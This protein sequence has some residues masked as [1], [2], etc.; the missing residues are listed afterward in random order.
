MHVPDPPN[1][2]LAN[3]IAANGGPEAFAA[4]TDSER[5]LKAVLDERADRTFPKPPYTMV[6]PP[7]PGAAATVDCGEPRAQTQRL[8]TMSCIG[9]T[10]ILTDLPLVLSGCLPGGAQ[11]RLEALD[12]S[13]VHVADG[14]DGAPVR[15]FCDA[16]VR[17]TVLAASTLF[18][19]SPD[20]AVG[21]AAVKYTAKV[22]AMLA[23]NT[24]ELN[25]SPRAGAD[26][27]QAPADSF[28][29]N[30]T[31]LFWRGPASDGGSYK[32]DVSDGR[33]GVYRMLARD[34]GGKVPWHGAMRSR[35]CIVLSAAQ[36]ARP[37]GVDTSGPTLLGELAE[38]TLAA[39][40][41]GG[42]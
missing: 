41:L 4:F 10:R 31:A 38:G 16:Q 27:D 18:T 1:A 20:D 7:T 13:D 37:D 23:Q 12:A 39:E 40:P 32:S 30:R 26:D 5:E 17:N 36:A 29:A 21:R 14:L 34:H 24:N 28:D 3:L 8:E 35:A 25:G 15:S 11:T 19:T 6:T 9:R 22:A 42:R 33:G 2:S